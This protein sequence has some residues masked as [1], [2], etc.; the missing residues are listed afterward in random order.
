MSSEL[1]GQTAVVV[2][3]PV[4][5]PRPAMTLRPSAVLQQRSADFTCLSQQGDVAAQYAAQRLLQLYPDVAMAESV[6]KLSEGKKLRS[7]EE[8]HIEMMAHLNERQDAFF[9]NFAAPQQ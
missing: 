9:S 3:P 2:S 4:V 5:L 8:R 6:Q 1:E 7:F